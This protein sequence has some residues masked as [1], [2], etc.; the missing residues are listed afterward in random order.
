MPLKTIVVAV[1]IAAIVL[2]SGLILLGLAGDFLV[3]WAWFSAVGY[4]SVFWTILSA[5]TVV[6]F[7]VFVCSGA[8][9]VSGFGSC[10]AGVCGC[11]CAPP[12]GP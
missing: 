6:F 11:G 8:F 2:V 12:S 5:K 9:L 10:G 3:D 4:L 1:I 7:A